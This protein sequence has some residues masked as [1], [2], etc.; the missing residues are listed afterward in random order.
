MHCVRI[1]VTGVW[2][3]SA[4]AWREFVLV[5]VELKRV[6]RLRSR[7]RLKLGRRCK[8]RRAFPVCDL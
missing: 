7:Q 5:S 1:C 2:L 4:C 6:D 3:R 8:A